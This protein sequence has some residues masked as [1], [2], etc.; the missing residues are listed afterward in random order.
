MDEVKKN[1]APEASRNDQ[2]SLE[3]WR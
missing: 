1:L 3:Q 2:V